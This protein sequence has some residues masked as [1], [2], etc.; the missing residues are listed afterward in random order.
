MKDYLLDIIQYTHSL[1]LIELAKVTET[2]S[3]TQVSARHTQEPVVIVEGK[4]NKPI[5]GF[6]GV[7]GL[8][9]LSKLKTIL[10]FDD[11][12]D[13]A[14]I[15]L[16]LKTDDNGNTEPSNIHF[17]TANK[18]FVNDYRLMTKNVVE[19]QVKKVTF[20]GKTWH[21]EFEP[22]VA[23]IQ[24]LKKQA[25]ANS[26]E[27]TFIM[28]VDNGDLKV[29]FGDPSTHSGN[30]VFHSGVA[31]NLNVE[32]HWPVK[33]FLSI[34]D[35]PGNKYIKVSDEGAAEITVDSGL[36]TWQYLIPGLAK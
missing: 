9:N 8:P 1:G 30:F 16:T 21:V 29:F 14:K 6:D 12:D 13:N 10:S 31:G 23:G 11:Y 24:R 3:E 15:N 25:S 27:P 7:F 28:K 18:D 35:L 20:H 19:T 4:Y 22:T 26:E 36:G 32:W 34:M 17:E 33:L 2:G 5:M